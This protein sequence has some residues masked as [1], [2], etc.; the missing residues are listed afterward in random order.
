MFLFQ[1]FYSGQK[2]QGEAPDWTKSDVFLKP[3][4]D[5]VRPFLQ[6]NTSEQSI[7]DY[8]LLL[9]EKLKADFGTTVIGVLS[10]KFGINTDTL[11]SLDF[12]PVKDEKRIA[13][14]NALYSSSKGYLGDIRA[15]E[16]IGATGV[17]AL[18]RMFASAILY[19]SENADVKILS[20]NSKPFLEICAGMSCKWVSDLQIAK[21]V[22]SGKSIQESLQSIIKELSAQPKSLGDDG[23]PN[24]KAFGKAMDR[25]DYS[26]VDKDPLKA[27]KDK[28]GPGALRKLE[29]FSANIFSICLQMGSGVA[30]G[31]PSGQEE[32][33]NLY[34]S[35]KQGSEE[36]LKKKSDEATDYYKHYEPPG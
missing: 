9:Y 17:E 33:P 25:I 32:Q 10:K 24:V 11:P 13:E 5:Y 26:K 31:A 7:R 16:N 2:K 3:L 1:K 21:D 20:K 18:S 36:F 34:T 4:E 35:G 19:V 29:A 12:V 8:A 14:L 28:F 23:P 6:K 22:L 27:Y 30:A 15:E